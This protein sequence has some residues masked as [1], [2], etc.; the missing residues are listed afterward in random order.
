MNPH[1]DTRTG[2][3]TV[4][5]FGMA[6]AVK[7]GNSIFVAVVVELCPHILFLFIRITFLTILIVFYGTYIKHISSPVCF[8]DQL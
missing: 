6:K 7:S 8:K 5:P 1:R 3:D 2:H 4:T